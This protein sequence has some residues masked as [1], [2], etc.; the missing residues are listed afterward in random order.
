MKKE[1]VLEAL[2]RLYKS[3]SEDYFAPFPTRSD[4]DTIRQFIN[5]NYMFEVTKELEELK[6]DVKR[7][8]YLLDRLTFGNIDV[9]ESERKRYPSGHKESWQRTANRL[10]K[11]EKH[12]LEKLSSINN[13]ESKKN[14]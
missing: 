14:E 7:Y 1:K 6:K 11:E 8:F 13:I 4:L 10:Y 2:N 3:Q 5:Q 9:I 12:L